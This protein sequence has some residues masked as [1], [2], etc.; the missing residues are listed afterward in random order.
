V[1][2]RD[3]HI[4]GFGHFADRTV[5]PLDLPITVF[6]GPNEAGKSTYL[7]FIRTVLFGFPQRLSN[8]HYPAL[9]GGRHGGRITIADDAGTQYAVQ[10]AQG[11]GTGPVTITTSAGETLGDDV[12]AQVLGHHSKDVF[13]SIFAFTLDELQSD[14]LLKDT[15][16]NSQIYSAGMGATTLPAAVRT[17]KSEKD[18]LFLRGGSKHQIAEAANKLR[19][20]ESR[21]AIVANN[22]AEYGTLTARLEQVEVEFQKLNDGRREYE[23]QLDQQRRLESAWDDWNDL[24]TTEQQLTEVPTIDDFPNDGVARLERLEER[25]R[26]ATREYD[27]AGERA[28]QAEAAIRTQVE[29]EGILNHTA[30]IRRLERGRTSFDNSA[31]DLP[32]RVA[33][34]TDHQSSLARTLKELGPGWD[35]AHLEGFDLSIAVR[36]E[37]SKYQSQLR[38]AT[39]ELS[40]R[41]SALTQAETALAEAIEAEGKAEREVETTPKP[42]LD[43]NEIRQRRTLVRTVSLKLGQ[44]DRIRQRVSDLRTQLDGLTNSAAPIGQKD[45]SRLVAAV[46]AVFGIGLLAGGAILGGTALPIGVVAGLAL[47]SIAVYLFTSGQSTE[48]ATATESPLAAP[49]RESLARAEAELAELRSALE[50]E[51]SPFGLESI[52][53]QALI[54]AEDSLDVEEAKLR[55]WTRLSEVLDGAKDLTKQRTSRRTES[56]NAVDLAGQQLDAVQSAWQEWLQARNILDTFTP[57]TVAELR[58]QVELGRSQLADVRSW[59]QRIE[60][61]EKDVREYTAIVEPLAVAFDV[62]FDVNDYRTVAAAADRLVELHEQVQQ[63][64]G[65]RTDAEAELEDAEHQLEERRTHLQVAEEEMGQLLESGGS[66]DAEHFR[67]RADLYGQRTELLMR[68]R[69]ALG[70]LQRLSGPGERLESLQKTLHETD[71]Q[72]IRD[73]A[74]RVEEE[75]ASAD[76]A[77][78]ELSTERGSLQRELARLVDEEESSKL[79]MERNLLLEQIQAHAREWV[80]RALAERLIEEARKKF[81]RERQPG[82]VRHAEKFFREI[83]DGRY[84]QVYAPLGQQ[85]ITVTDDAGRAK[86]PSQLSRGTREQ[87]FLSLRFGLVREL[88]E[89]TET[90]P[91]VVDEVLVN[92]DPAR[93]LRAARAFVELSETNQVLVFTCHPTTVELFQNA[94]VKSGVQEPEVIAI[95]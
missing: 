78:Q 4:D 47:L 15:N 45:K 9:S 8:Q 59:R 25:V 87:L 49:V 69:D 24:V 66:D 94:A 11:R 12:L 91:V 19:D 76:T 79:R 32:E 58:G 54:A 27:L 63:L 22:A 88:G 61:I 38:E 55:D 31:H 43:T 53:E 67:K 48:S 56:R 5:G 89:R 60:A 2:I 72:A 20:I 10:R 14:D 23:S 68:R 57:E 40:S 16:V 3:L 35:E 7:E 74:L 51:A 39:G 52:D 17:L 33:E 28:A 86:K 13:Q 64:V 93:A 34:L 92:F 95:G 18:D 46:S 70:R 50:Q 80:K 65:L 41:E 21:L 36:E 83:T 82:V 81:E 77:I 1:R 26:A 90:L 44:I 73:D 62:T 84:R 6:Y 30:D 42:S 75:R 29:H 37:I 71:I 85:T